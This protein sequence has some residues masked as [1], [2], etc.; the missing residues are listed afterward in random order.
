MDHDQGI[1]KAGPARVR[2]H[3]IQMAWRWIRYQPESKL[4]RWFMERT[5]DGHGRSRKRMIVALARKLLVALWRLATQGVIPE[6]A[7]IK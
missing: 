5:R 1:T 6:G 2:R 3:L 7:I 4:T